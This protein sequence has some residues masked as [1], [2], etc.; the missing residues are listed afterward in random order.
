MDKKIIREI[1]QDANSDAYRV[2]RSALVS[3]ILDQAIEE[4]QPG[5]NTMATISFQTP[6]AQ[7]ISPEGEDLTNRMRMMHP[8]M[9]TI[10][11]Q[12][13]ALTSVDQVDDKGFKIMVAYITYD[14]Q[15][16]NVSIPL[17][18]IVDFQLKSKGS[19]E[20]RL[21]LKERGESDRFAIERMLGEQNFPDIG[22][23]EL[24]WPLNGFVKD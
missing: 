13:A 17:S 23:G 20:I 16:L 6:T 3:K 15:P 12:D 11:L 8:H 21:A 10:I 18:S 9:M 22:D 14:G 2:F 19:P 4:Y 5:N 1:Y 7:F 24:A